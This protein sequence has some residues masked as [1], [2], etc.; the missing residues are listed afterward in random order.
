MNATDPRPGLGR[1]LAQTGRLIDAV[2]PDQ[3]AAPTPCAEYDVQDLVSHLLSVVRRIDLALRGGNALD[4]P[5]LTDAD[6][7]VAAWASYR[8]ALESTLADDEVLARS[9]RLPW[10]T[11]PGA[12]AI[13]AYTGEFATHGWD[14]ATAIDRQDLL[15]ERLAESCLPMARQ[16]VPAEH[17]GGEIP[18]GPVVAV[19]ADAPAYS[20]LAGWM[21]REPAWSPGQA[22]RVV[23]SA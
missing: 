1:A 18:F 9:C 2:G 10:G 17:R 14:L 19:P 13:G 20:Q 23:S 21:G 12:A 11:L 5:L 4:V 15:D 22:S 7:Q 3:G 8:R 6:D 16:F